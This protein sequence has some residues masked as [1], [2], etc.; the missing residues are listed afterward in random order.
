[1][2]QRALLLFGHAD[3]QQTFNHDLAERYERGLLRAGAQVDRIDLATLSFDPVLH[4]G[5]RA[6]QPLEPDL[7]RVQRAI[8]RASHLAWV[9]PIYWASPPTL[10]RGLIDRLFLPRWAFRYEQGSALPQG[11]LA[12]RS[13]RV[14]MTMDSP[15]WWYTGVNHRCVHRSFGTATLSFCGLKPVRFT[16]VHDVH[17]L[18]ERARAAWAAKLETIGANDGRARLEPGVRELSA[19]S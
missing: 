11:L 19:S 17:H 4:A 1:M 7:Q 6:V 16:T 9:F 12:G 10:V 15:G 14:I 3:P 5:Y 2:S 13:A 8:E 18:S